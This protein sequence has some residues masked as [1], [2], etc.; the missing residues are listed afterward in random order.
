[1]SLDYPKLQAKVRKHKA[2]LTRAKNSKDNDK[3]IAVCKAFFADFGNDPYPDNWML[4]QRAKEDAEHDKEM[5][6][7]PS[8]L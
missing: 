4:W 7:P 2:A 1:M 3:I 6:K 5:A 8:F